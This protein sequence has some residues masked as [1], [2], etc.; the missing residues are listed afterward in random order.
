MVN[1]KIIDFTKEERNIIAEYVYSYSQD[2]L[3]KTD[4]I[5]VLD[6]MD[7]YN[8]INTDDY[9]AFKYRLENKTDNTSYDLLKLLESK[10]SKQQGVSIM[11]EY[12]KGS[13]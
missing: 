2:I 1:N 6:V 10:I 4:A 9:K 13:N 12:Y 11:E 8:L 3:I 5:K 7:K